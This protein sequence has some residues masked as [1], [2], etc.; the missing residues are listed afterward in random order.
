MTSLPVSTDSVRIEL[1]FGD[2]LATATLAGTPAA[3]EFVAMLPLQLD[4]DDPMGQ[5][6]SGRLPGSLDVTGV[7]AV[8]DPAIGHIYYWAPSHTLAIFYEDFGHTVPDPGLVP[9]GVVDIG[10][11]ELA[12]RRQ[13]LHGSDR[14]C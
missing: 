5:A 10:I 11:D 6:K 8:F 13:P 4:L 9:L 14:L 1:H 2:E 7:E 12:E 3:R